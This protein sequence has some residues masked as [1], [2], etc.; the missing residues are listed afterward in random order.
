VKLK[1]STTAIPLSPGRH[2]LIEIDDNIDH[3][4]SPSP[5]LALG[6]ETTTVLVY[7]VLEKS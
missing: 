4:G 1:S 6:L 5:E 7:G 2:G 3:F